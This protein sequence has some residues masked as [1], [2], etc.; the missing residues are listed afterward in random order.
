MTSIKWQCLPSRPGFPCTI[1]IHSTYSYLT[2]YVF[3]S[4]YFVY[5]LS[6]FP[7]PQR[8]HREIRDLATFAAPSPAGSVAGTWWGSV[9]F[10]GMTMI[11]VCPLELCLFHLPHHLKDGTVSLFLCLYLMHSDGSMQLR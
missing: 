1:F 5:C 6:A 4:D 7:H 3:H 11:N 10:Y 9:I 8:E 2:D